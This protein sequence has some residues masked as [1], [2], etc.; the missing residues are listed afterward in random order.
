MR[1]VLTNMNQHCIKGNKLISCLLLVHVSRNLLA[2]NGNIVQ[3]KFSF[4]AWPMTR[5]GF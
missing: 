4:N 1:A 3:K 5:K 2:N